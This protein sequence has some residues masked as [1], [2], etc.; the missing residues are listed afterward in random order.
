[1]SSRKTALLGIL[2]LL[3]VGILFQLVTALDAYPAGI[4][5][6]TPGVSSVFNGSQYPAQNTG[7]EAGNITALSLSSVGPT[8]HWQGFYGEI[9]AEIVLEDAVGNTMYNWS[10][11]EPQGEIY[12]T[13]GTTITWADVTCINSA[14]DVTKATEETLHDIPAADGDGIDETFVSTTLHPD[15]QIAETTITGCNTT[16]TFVSDGPQTTSFP[17]FLLEDDT[18][19]HAVYGTMIE[20]KTEGSTSDPVGFDGSTHDFQLMVPENG[21]GNNAVLTTYYFYVALA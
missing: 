6:I 13:V 12:A 21:T 7:A 1:M 20:N 19:D 3:T 4:T 18:N 17:E 9:S 16:W 5:S 15:F 2:V 14:G 11:A 8:T 10:E